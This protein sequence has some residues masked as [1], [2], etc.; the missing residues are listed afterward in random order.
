MIEVLC[1]K[2]FKSRII[3]PVK[4]NIIGL[5][6]SGAIFC[7]KGAIFHLDQDRSSC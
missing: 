5:C 2:Q 7:R 1:V 3:T 6:E 4:Y